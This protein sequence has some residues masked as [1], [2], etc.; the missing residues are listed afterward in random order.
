MPVQK[1]LTMLMKK[2]IKFKDKPELILDP[3]YYENNL[4]CK[5]A[6]F[7]DTWQQ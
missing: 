1:P 2:I 3:N 6:Y 7:V 4:L 5:V